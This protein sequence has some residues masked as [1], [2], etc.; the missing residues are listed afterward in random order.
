MKFL[1]FLLF[2]SFVFAISQEKD[3]S[4]ESKGFKF[5]SLDVESILTSGPIASLLEKTGLNLA[6]RYQEAKKKAAETG[7]LEDIP[8]IT[9]QNYESLVVNEPL[10]MDEE[11]R[12]VW[13]IEISMPN[14][15]PL[16]K[17]VDS[18]FEATF[19]ISRSAPE[20]A[21]PYVKWA[22]INY[23]DV[24]KIT[25]KWWIWRA[26]MIVVLRHHGRELRFYPPSS[27]RMDP[28]SLYE[29]LELEEWR[30]TEPWTGDF[31][32]G[33]KYEPYMEK[34]A[35]WSEVLYNFI[36]SVPRWVL[37]L[38]TG[39]LAST[40]LNLFHSQSKKPVAKPIVKLDS[41]ADSESNTK[42]DVRLDEKPE[43]KPVS[44]ARAPRLAQTAQADKA[45]ADTSSANS[46]SDR[47]STS[48]RTRET[49]RTRASE[50]SPNPAKRRTKRQP[51]AK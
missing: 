3:R 6:E 50:G 25:T 4:Q 42:A 18:R 51:V 37:L 48:S 47:E 28:E 1:A 26:P 29:F 23:L 49:R 14:R 13:F 41:K 10:S 46:G 44:T 21:L 33:G 27:L 11:L 15:D 5:P 19:N 12:R 2:I 8:L 31:A 34:L 7:W 38:I 43:P 24:T 40:M 32:P 22:R 36:T 9:D 30:K 35:G 39:A 20:K 17:F 16:T 45:T